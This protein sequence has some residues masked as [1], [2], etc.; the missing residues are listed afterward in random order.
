M[1]RLFDCSIAPPRVLAAL[2][3]CGYLMLSSSGM[4]QTN[5]PLYWNSVSGTGV[6]WDT[7]SNWWTTPTGTNSGAAPGSTNDAVFNGTNVNGD[8]TVQLEVP[9]AALG[10]YFNNSG[11]TLIESSSA[12]NEV[13]SI[14]ADGITSS[15]S[16][17]AVTIGSATNPL[18]IALLGSQSWT[19]SSFDP[20]T[21]ASGVSLANSVSTPSTLTLGGN[22][23]AINVMG[24]VISNGGGAGASLGVNVVGGT[25]VFAANNTYTGPTNISGNGVIRLQGTQAPT[26]GLQ[27]FYGFQGNANDSVNGNNGTLAFASPGTANPTFVS[28][29]AGQ[30]ISFNGTN[31]FVVLPNTS[32]LDLSG[33]YTI[34]LWVN[35]G[36]QTT[37]DPTLFSARNGAEQNFDVQILGTHLHG[38]IGTNGAGWLNTGADSVSGAITPGVWQMVT[39]SVSSTG[40][41]IYVNGVNEGS[42]SLGGIPVLMSAANPGQY[43]TV[44]SQAAGGGTPSQGNSFVGSIEDLN[45]YNT[46][47]SQTQVNA[48]FAAESSAPILPAATP[49]SIASGS[50]LGSGG[51]QPDG[52]VAF[53]LDDG[54]QWRL[55]DQQR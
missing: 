46:A 4:A 5:S 40:Y 39:Y 21:V 44:G 25:W 49:L 18:S 12:S 41:S 9:A 2:L 19:N 8:T 53:R 54:R 38:D 22:N 3:A 35:P 23:S 45:I 51:Q 55:G 10:L 48:L 34:S 14:G 13:L 31:Q 32:S 28:G 11:S 30:A 47:L 42:G 52:R 1:Q 24:G 20:L 33:A 16:S 7:A 50:T 6:F 37:A 17:G 43:L 15:N 29:F 26:A 36:T 27:A